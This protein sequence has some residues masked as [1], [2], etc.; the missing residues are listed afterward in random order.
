[1]ICFEIQVNGEALTVAGANDAEVIE[2]SLSLYPKLNEAHIV[3]EGSLIPENNAPIDARWLNRQL[4]LGSEVT[5]KVLEAVKSSSPTIGHYEPEAA[6]Q[7]SAPLL[8]SFC[9]TPQNELKSSLVVSNHA[10]I[11]KEC[12]AELSGWVNET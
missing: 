7:S 3:V 10:A 4:E 5:I 12:L 11:C 8:C 6:K 1:V 2:A 9:S